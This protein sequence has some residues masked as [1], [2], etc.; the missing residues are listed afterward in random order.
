MR[1]TFKNEKK[2]DLQG[3][4]ALDCLRSWYSRTGDV[5]ELADEVEYKKIEKMLQL[6]TG[7]NLKLAFSVEVSVVS[8]ISFRLH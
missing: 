2:N 4:T 1:C 8:S 5:L 7:E 3:N 6:V